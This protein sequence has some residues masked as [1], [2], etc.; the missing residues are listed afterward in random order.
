[1]KPLKSIC[2]SALMLTWVAAGVSAEQFR[3]DINPA[4]QY[5]QA[6]LL[7]PELSKEDRNYLFNTEWRGQKLPERFGELV[8]QYDN[9]FKLVREAAQQKTPCDWG[10]DMTAGPATLLPG[11]ARNKGIASAA[12]LRAAW[13]L[14]EGRPAEA[15]DDLLAAFT[16]ARHSS[17]DGLLISVLVQIAMENIIC[18]AVAENFQRFP[19]E[20]L[21]QLADGFDAAPPRSTV[22][23]SVSREKAVFFDWMVG[24]ILELR[25]QNPEDDRN[26]MEAI[27]NSCF[28]EVKE[29]RQGEVNP[30]QRLFTASG[31]TSDGLLKLIQDAEPVFPRLAGILALPR[32]Q[33]DEELKQFTAEIH[34]SPN[35]LVSEAF[36]GF[37]K[38]R[39]KELAI[40]VELAMVRAAVE[41]KLH[42]DQGLQSVID[43]CGQGPFAFQRFVFEGVDRGFELKS[44]YEGRGFQEVMI[45][46]EK[47]GTPFQV[48]WKDAGK[49]LPTPAVRN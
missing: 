6:F 12:R 22:A 45:F 10:I 14:E 40:L 27:H 4:L 2:L 26:V 11:L 39:P 32:A 30:W 19:P 24:R 15:R 28:P 41:F 46:V 29:D 17:N 3:T 43:P 5:Y 47:E 1:M 8:R 20:T 35:P 7:A 49:A 42:G 36:P 25:K 9:Q 31:G 16:L 44:A 37:E 34:R 38:C 18:S 48:N 13:D 23:G 21:M 33:A